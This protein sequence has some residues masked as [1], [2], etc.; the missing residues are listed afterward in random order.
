MVAIAAVTNSSFGQPPPSCL[1][2]GLRSI[3]ATAL[4]ARFP[5]SSAGEDLPGH[6]MARARRV[7]TEKRQT[8]DDATGTPRTRQIDDFP[9]I[10]SIEG[11]S[12]IVITLTRERFYSIKG[13]YSSEALGR[14]H[15]LLV[16]RLNQGLQCVV[17]RTNAR[18]FSPL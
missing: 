6:R 18:F 1:C 2:I 3:F 15:V 9:S 12:I 10:T 5:G 11:L 13:Y 14:R 16:F 4:A 7:S 17:E 8:G